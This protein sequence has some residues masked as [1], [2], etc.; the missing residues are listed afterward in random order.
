MN[1]EEKTVNGVKYMCLPRYESFISEVEVDFLLVSR[2]TA[3]LKYTPNI[4]KAFF[5]CEDAVPIGEL[6]LLEPR[7]EKMFCVSDIHRQN[8]SK[9]VSP[10]VHHKIDYV[11][12]MVDV[13]HPCF[14]HDKLFK[15]YVRQN[16][17]SDTIRD[18]GYKQKHTFIYSSCCTRGLVIALDW[19]IKIKETHKDAIFKIFTDFNNEY[20]KKTLG[21][22]ADELKKR[23]TD[24]K[25][26]CLNDRVTKEILYKEM[27]HTEYW[28][29]PTDFEETFC[30]TGAEAQLAGCI[31]IQSGIAALQETVAMAPVKSVDAALKLI[32]LMDSS[33]TVRAET[34]EKCINKGKE[35]SIDACKKRWSEILR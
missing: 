12:N 9:I 24:T 20:V 14:N 5:L 16:K 13:N 8:L 7:L 11:Y 29:Y 17:F 28:L 18:F 19:F 15:Q 26:V 33:D 25:D 1:T 32:N 34:I 22:K 3:A 30:I 2:F 31:P 6:N 21:E 35:Y 10:A 4:K 23:L 27:I